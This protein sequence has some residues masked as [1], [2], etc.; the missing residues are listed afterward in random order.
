MQTLSSTVQILK[1]WLRLAVLPALLFVVIRGFFLEAFTIPTSSMEGTLLVGD[2]LLVNKAL[3]GAEIPGT[4][5]R[6]PAFRE[7]RRSDVVVF[8]PHHDLRRS[9]VKRVVGIPGDTLAMKGK[10]LYVN[11]IPQDE[12]Y[13]EHRDRRGD[14]IHP[15]MAW[16]SDFLSA[17]TYRRRYAPSR[18]NWGPLV[19]PPLKYFVLGDNR[20]NSEGGCAGSLIPF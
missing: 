15:D 18:D 9:Y 16:Q 10:T 13:A 12:G 4:N 17:S 20:D 8:S 6:L 11:G 1:R 7:P 2:F 5:A 14:A 3:Y 19:V